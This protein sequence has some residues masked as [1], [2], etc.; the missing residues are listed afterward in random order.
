MC[1]VKQ[2]LMGINS[3]LD[4]TEKKISDLEHIAIENSQNETQKK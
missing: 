1:E 4:N 3:R 2:K